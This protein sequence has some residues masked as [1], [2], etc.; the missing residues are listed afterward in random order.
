MTVEQAGLEHVFREEHG[1]VV[2]TLIRLFGD[3]DVAEEAVQ[4]AFLVATQ[5]CPATGAPPNPG[6]WILTTARNK[7]IDRMRRE[8]YRPDRHLQAVR[9]QEHDEFVE[10]VGPV[11]DDRLR[12]MFTCCNP[13][14][15]TNAQVALTLRLL[16]GL[17]TAA[18]QYIVDHV[19]PGTTISR[20]VEVTNDTAETQEVQVYPAAASISDGN[21]QFGEGRAASELTTWTTV[22]PSTVSPPSGGE[23]LA[24]V[25]IAVPADASPGERYGVIWAELPA[26]VPEGGIGAVNRVG[27]RIYLSVGEGGEPASDFAIA[28]FEARRDAEANP[29]VAATVENTGSRALDLSGEMT[30]TNGPGGLSA[31]P[32]DATLG[33]TLGI[34]QTEPVLVTL[35]K[36]LPNGPWDAR[37]VLRSGMTE[38][39]ATATITFPEAA[40]TSSEP[41]ATAVETDDGS[42]LLPIIIAVVVLL[43]LFLLTFL[44]MRRR[45]SRQ[46]S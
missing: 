25:T 43:A 9:L 1:R 27:V 40:E 38:R 20:R 15:A 13:A 7:A 34:G 3:I 6:G 41:V 32:F 30:L 8:S 37:I 46:E 44:L 17:E 33:T 16:G 31:G 4:E 23:S 42:L 19:A 24:T 22:E 28:S 35:E 29:M 21:F 14:L 11:T 45:R 36:A 18:M 26:A 5:R 2:A 12:L 39:E 10:E